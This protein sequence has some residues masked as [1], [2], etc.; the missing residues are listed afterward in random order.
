M[1]FSALLQYESK[2]QVKPFTAQSGWFMN[3]QTWYETILHSARRL[4]LFCV[5]LRTNSDYFP[6][7]R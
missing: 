2:V 5:V 6:T 4:C 7:Q 3:C 1:Y